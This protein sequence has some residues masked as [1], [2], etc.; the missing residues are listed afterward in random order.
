VEPAIIP[1]LSGRGIPFLPATDA[2]TT[3][4]LTRHTIYHSGIALREYAVQR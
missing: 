2:R 1:V 4:A 3:F